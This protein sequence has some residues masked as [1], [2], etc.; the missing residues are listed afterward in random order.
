[1]F[2]SRTFAGY[3]QTVYSREV[4]QEIGRIF[5]KGNYRTMLFQMFKQRIAIE[6][7]NINEN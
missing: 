5:L 1:M 6:L 4:V 7:H 2:I 3:D